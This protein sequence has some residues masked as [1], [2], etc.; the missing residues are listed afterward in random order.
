MAA[1]GPSPVIT[2]RAAL[3]DMDGTLVDSRA[4]VEKLWLRWAD[5]HGLDHDT[6][7]RTVHGR[8]GH[9]SM[10][11][12][13]PDRSAEENHRE[14]QQ[15]LATESVDTG[16]IISI[17]GAAELLDAL[18]ELPHALVTSADARLAIARMEAA[19]LRVPE[20]RITAEDVTASK[21][22]PEGFLQAAERLGVAPGECVVFEDSQAGV[23]AGL[24]AG[25]PVVGVGAHAAAHGPTCA[26]EDLTDLRIAVEDD[27]GFT[28]LLDD[29]PSAHEVQ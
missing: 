26:V 23:E 19:G 27:G 22:S 29:G 25:M 16:G 7:L 24:A 8:Q 14:N 28:V 1:P 3:L 12:L 15:M 21:P 20:H 2:A 11:I 9:E 17:G 18:Q 10:A 13:L 6:V 5:Q 4:V